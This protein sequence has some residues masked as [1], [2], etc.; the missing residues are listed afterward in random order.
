MC[1]NDGERSAM[2]ATQGLYQIT[3]SDYALAAELKANLHGPHR[4]DVARLI[5]HILW[6]P[7][8]GRIV[9]V[10]TRKHKQWRLARL[11]GVRGEAIELIEGPAYSNRDDALWGAFSMRWSLITGSSLDV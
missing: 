7:L 11:S 5:S 4:P 2:T 8:Q 1:P 3:E 10:C 9:L 6:T